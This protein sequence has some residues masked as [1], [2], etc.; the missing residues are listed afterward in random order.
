MY[1]QRGVSVRTHEEECQYVHTK[2][3]VSTYTQTGVSVRTY[4]EE[5]H[6]NVVYRNAH[7]CITMQSDA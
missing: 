1:K 3:S 2:W 5:R 7:G 6:S 4:K